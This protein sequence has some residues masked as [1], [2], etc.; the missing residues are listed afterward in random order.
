MNA[1]MLAINANVL[2]HSLLLLPLTFSFL[3]LSEHVI[4]FCHSFI[5]ATAVVTSQLFILF[6]SHLPLRIFALHYQKAGSPDPK[7]IQPVP[8]WDEVACSGERVLCTPIR[9]PIDLRS[10]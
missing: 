7:G 2:L 1:V 10:V 3:P 5:S 4:T 8:L 9:A 6:C